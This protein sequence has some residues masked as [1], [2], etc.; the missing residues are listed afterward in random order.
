MYADGQ[1]QLDA[2]AQAFRFVARIGH[3][4]ARFSAGGEPQNVVPGGAPVSHPPG[5]VKALIL[6]GFEP[7]AG[8]AKTTLSG[9]NMAYF[10]N[11]FFRTR[12]YRLDS[13]NSRPRGGFLRRAGRPFGCLLKGGKA[14]AASRD[15]GLE[16]DGAGA[17]N[18]T[19]K[20]Y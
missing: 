15:S 11:A 19:G 9:Y 17:A 4:S 12:K 7:A 10:L 16:A 2:L 18:C 13:P 20:V 5:G 14:L 8:F 6:Q 3:F 1:R